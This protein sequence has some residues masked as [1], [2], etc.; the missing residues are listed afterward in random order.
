MS[1]FDRPDSISNTDLMKSSGS[2]VGL[3]NQTVSVNKRGEDCMASR[4]R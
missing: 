3:R 1:S 2:S 4:V